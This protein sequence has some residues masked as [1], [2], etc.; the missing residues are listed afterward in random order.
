MFPALLLI[1]ASQ[2][3]LSWQYSTI[4]SKIT[5][6]RT[7]IFHFPHTHTLRGRGKGKCAAAK[8]FFVSWRWFCV[9]QFQL[10]LTLALSLCLSR[11][12]CLSALFLPA[13]FAEL[14]RLC[15]CCCC[16]CCCCFLCV[17]IHVKFLNAPF[18]AFCTS[19]TLECTRTHTHSVSQ[20]FHTPRLLTGKEA[21]LA[22]SNCSC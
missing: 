13:F 2:P 12:A 4:F 15:Y 22:L 10:P 7:N 9:V 3:L 8:V 18:V 19:H 21:I 16:H 1:T 11:P 5:K 6:K 20:P 14:L 17:G